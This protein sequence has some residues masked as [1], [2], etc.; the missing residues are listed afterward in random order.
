MKSF[1]NYLTRN[2]FYV[3]MKPIRSLRILASCR[4]YSLP[5]IF[6][7]SPLGACSFLRRYEDFLPPS[8][9][10]VS[11]SHA[12]PRLVSFPHFPFF[13]SEPFVSSQKTDFCR[14]LFKSPQKHLKLRL[15][16]NN[17]SIFFTESILYIAGTINKFYVLIF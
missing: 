10:S 14:F 7:P 6:F 4:T 17:V 11:G 9:I 5:W 13:S 8:Q 3:F 15:V 12:S 2:Q 16:F 1:S